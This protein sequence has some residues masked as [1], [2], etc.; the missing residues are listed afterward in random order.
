[1]CVFGV[2]ASGETPGPPPSVMSNK[3]YLSV[4]DYAMRRT[5]SVPATRNGNNKHS[6]LVYGSATTAGSRTSALACVFD[7]RGATIELS[8]SRAS[9]KIAH[10][11]RQPAING[12]ER[13]WGAEPGTAE[14]VAR[15]NDGTRS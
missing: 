3:R 5:H 6:A 9:G 2:G 14:T 10:Q 15:E 11:P 7:S 4:I 12:K 13:V 8:A 1:M